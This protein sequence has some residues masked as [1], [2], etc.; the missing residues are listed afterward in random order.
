MGR[1]SERKATLLIAAQRAIAEHGTSVRLNQI[2]R[3]AGVSSSSILYHYPEIEELLMEANRAGMERFY[4]QRLEAIGSI[5]D[6]A[7]RLYVAITLGVP[8]GPEDEEVRLLCSMGGEAARNS[9]FALLLTSLY[10]RQVGM[11][12]DVL[13]IGA[14]TGA[15]A[16]AQPAA[17]IARNLVALEDAY[18]YRIMANHPRLDYATTVDLILDYAK[19][20]TGHPHLGP[21]RETTRNERNHP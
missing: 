4:S 6:P 2:A 8:S 20:A 15:F 7:E 12:C 18:G 13:Q 3:V 11:Y 21:R 16:L 19:L 10:D 14:E 5:T 1:P 17:T 9:L